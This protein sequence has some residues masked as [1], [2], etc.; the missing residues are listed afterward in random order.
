MRNTFRPIQHRIGHAQPVQHAGIVAHMARLCLGTK[1][2][3]QPALPVVI[4]NAGAG[5]QIGQLVAAIFS[6]PHH[7]PFIAGIGGTVA[8][9]QEAHHP[10]HQ[11]RVQQRPHHQRAMPH[12]Q[13]NDRLARRIGASP[14]R[15]HAGRNLR[16]IGETRL[17][18]GLGLPV[19]HRYLVPGLVQIPRGCH[20][21]N[22]AT[23]DRDLQSRTPKRKKGQEAVPPGPAGG[24]TPPI[25]SLR[26]RRP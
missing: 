25:F 10:A 9:A 1:K 22:A 26:F 18:P 5:P 24:A 20:A 14:G 4:G 11:R 3:Q 12:Q 21:N 7:A 15:R 17:H 6:Q 16:R 2:L 19:D 13:P 8:V 23:Q